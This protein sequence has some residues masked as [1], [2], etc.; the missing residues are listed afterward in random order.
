MNQYIVWIFC[1][2][3]EY[4]KPLTGAFV[5]KG[6]Q[7]ASASGKSPATTKGI[8]TILAYSLAKSIS[9]DDFKVELISTLQESKIYYYGFVC[10][11]YDGRMIWNVGNIDGD[12]DISR[13][14]QMKA[15]W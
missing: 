5:E 10:S 3:P 8:S 11:A 2:T 15:L 6:Y 7:V 12:T 9:S 14:L 13:V 4:N 1:L